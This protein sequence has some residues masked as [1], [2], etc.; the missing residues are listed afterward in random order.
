MGQVLSLASPCLPQ[1]GQAA[2]LASEAEEEVTL[3]SLGTDLC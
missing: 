2:R 3:T 1:L